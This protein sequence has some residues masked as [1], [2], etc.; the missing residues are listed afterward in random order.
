MRCEKS[1]D[2]TRHELGGG[3]WGVSR[4]ET[5]GGGARAGRG[6]QDEEKR[7]AKEEGISMH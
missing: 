1:I 5:G 3:W 7:G 4:I 2:G 6:G